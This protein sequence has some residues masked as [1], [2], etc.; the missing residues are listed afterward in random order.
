[1]YYVPGR[2][3][4]EF[5]AFLWY[6]QGH[7]VPN[8]KESVLPTGS[9]DLIIRL[10]GVRTCDSVIC[11]PHTRPVVV[12][13]TSHQELLGV[14]FRVGGAFPFLQC[15]VIDL[16]NTAHSINDLWPERDAQQLLCM[17]REAQTGER[18]CQIIEKWLL[19]LAED[20]LEKHPAV[21]FAIRK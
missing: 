5:V 7:Q 21:M 18:K 15:P 6:Y 17:L 12:K 13:T 9:V 11:G 1:M 8:A 19:H 14:H 3:L 10:D 4:S 2:P 20:R 16:H